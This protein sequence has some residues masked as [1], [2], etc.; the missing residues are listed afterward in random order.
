MLHAL[1][2][3]AVAGEAP[4]E[5]QRLLALERRFDRERPA[6]T[7][8][9]AQEASSKP[10]KRPVSD[11]LARL[12]AVLRAALASPDTYGLCRLHHAVLERD[13]ERVRE[14]CVAGAETEVAAG[15]SGVLPLH[16]AVLAGDAQPHCLQALIAGG[17]NVDAPDTRGVTALHAACSLNFPRLTT[18]LLAAGAAPE[19][20]GAHGVPPLQMAGWSN[21]AEAAEA[22]L[23]GG[24]SPN[25]CDERRFTPNSPRSKSS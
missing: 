16:L 18:L 4:P 9:L 17:A 10:G 7:R 20:R 2:L 23:A 5:L 19:A 24:A 13:A 12:Q 25:A 6:L 15:E 1:V 11:A 8:L 3:L 22:M 14:L 21:A